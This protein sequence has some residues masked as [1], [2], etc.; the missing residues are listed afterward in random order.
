M[1]RVSTDQMNNDLQYWLRRTEDRTAR[2]ETRIAR[3]TRIAELRDDPIA[4]AHAVRYDSFL[5]RLARFEKNAA[6]AEDRYRISEGYVRQAID[7]V[8]RVREL[9]VQGANGVFTEQDTAYMAAEVNELLEELAAVGNAHGPDGRFIFSGTEAG[10]RPFRLVQ[11]FVAGAGE[12]QTIDVQYVGNI[13]IREAEISQGAYSVLNQP[14][15][16]VFW[17]ERQRI[18]SSLDAGDFRV[19][20]SSTIRVN[21]RAID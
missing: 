13:A 19:L 12:E 6:F 15:N 16:E 17:A 1:R 18:F 21:G 5:A 9:A 3:Q 20:Q 8:Q 4:A 10:T 2:L 14:G 11:G 7:I